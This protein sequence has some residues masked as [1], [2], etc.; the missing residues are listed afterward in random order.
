MSLWWWGNIIPPRSRG[1]L[2][3]LTGRRVLPHHPGPLDSRPA[4][5]RLAWACVGFQQEKVSRVSQLW[6]KKYDVGHL[7]FWTCGPAVSSICSFRGSDT[8]PV[9]SSLQL[10]I[11]NDLD[12]VI[13]RIEYKCYVLHAAICKALFPVY[14]QILEPLARC[15]EVIDGY[16]CKT[17]NTV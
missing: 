7:F 9:R 4:H 6:E 16:T 1:R 5:A 3:H 15:V 11:L 12:P 8:L 13:V 17:V 2:M 10:L 14:A